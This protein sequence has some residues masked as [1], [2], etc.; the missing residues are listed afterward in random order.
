MQARLTEAQVQFKE[1]FPSGDC[2]GAWRVASLTTKQGTLAPGVVLIDVWRI[3]DGQVGGRAE[4]RLLFAGL[5]VGEQGWC[6]ACPLP[7][8]CRPYT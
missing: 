2:V 1:I 3:K 7:L 4:E 8:P 5:R 6:R